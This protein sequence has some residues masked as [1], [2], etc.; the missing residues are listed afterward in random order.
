MTTVVY[1]DGVL[2]SDSQATEVDAFRLGVCEKIFELKNGTLFGAAGDADDRQLRIL[3]GSVDADTHYDGLPTK[4]ELIETKTHCDALWVFPDGSLYNI[5]IQYDND[6]DEWR[7]YITKLD[8]EYAAVGTGKKF[9]YG[10]LYMGATAEQ[11]VEAAAE[12]DVNTGGD[13]QTMEIEIE[14]E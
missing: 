9:A 11:A 8:V 13:V 14:D 5:D 1:R 3:L 2:A 7:A 10:A 12:F 4:D 6:D